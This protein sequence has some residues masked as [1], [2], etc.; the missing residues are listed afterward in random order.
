[1]SA[2]PLLRGAA[3]VLRRSALPMRSSWS[4]SSI[5]QTGSIASATTR[6]CVTTLNVESQQKVREDGPVSVASIPGSSLANQSTAQQ[7]LAAHL[8]EADPAMFE[9]IENASIHTHRSE[10][11]Q[12][13]TEAWKR[14]D[15]IFAVTGEE[16]TEALHQPHS[17]REL[18]ITGCAGCIRQP[19]AEYDAHDLY[20]DPYG[21]QEG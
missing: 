11:E 3:R 19:H 5:S 15:V 17:F 2:S 18:H 1:M 6:R 16:P 10:R 20:R 9:I 21:E 12:D 8:K 14:A 7:A 13:R 4:N